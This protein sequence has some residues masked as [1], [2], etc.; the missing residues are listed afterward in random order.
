MVLL[1]DWI[2]TVTCFVATLVLGYAFVVAPKKWLRVLVIL[3]ILIFFG[4]F[5]HGIGTLWSD[6]RAFR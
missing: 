3:G 5:V 4:F 1:L 6:Y 2:T